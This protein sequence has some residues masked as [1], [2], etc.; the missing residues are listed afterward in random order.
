MN[1]PITRHIRECEIRVDSF[2]EDERTVEV[3]WAAGA[4]VK[5]RSWETGPY[6][7]E[8]SMKPEHIRLDR[9]NSGAMSLLDTHDSWSIENR[10]GTVVA[11]TVRFE[12]GRAF[13]RVKI[14]RK[15]L[16]ERILSD[17][18]DGMP[19]PVSVG[20]KIHAYE[21]KDPAEEG[22]LPTR[23]LIDWEPFEISAVP[24]PA[25]PQAQSRNQE[26]ENEMPPELVEVEDEAHVR[27]PR[28]QVAKKAE[29]R[30]I[31]ARFMNSADDEDR[32][33]MLEATRGMSA[34][35]VRL[36]ILEHRADQED[37]TATHTHYGTDFGGQSSM[38]LRAEALYARMTGNTP[39]EQAR[40]FMEASLLDHAR[41][42]LQERG[43]D[44]RMMGRDEI[45]RRSAMHTTSDFPI[46]LQST[47]LRVLRDA[48]E[49]AR[50]PIRSHLS[51][52]TTLSD[53]R[54]K[55]GVRITDIGL[56][57]KV[58]EHGEVTS[59]TRGE[60][61][62]ESYK[63]DTFARL[64]SMTRQA[65]INDDLSAFSDFNRTAG[66]MAAE[67]ENELLFSILAENAYAGPTMAEDDNAMFHANHG[68][69]GSAVALSVDALSG[70]RKLMR[71]QRAPAN[72]D[73]HRPFLSAKAKYLV[74]GPELETAAEKVLADITATKTDDVNP[75]S[76]KL[77]LLVENRIEDYS[78][79]LFADPAAVPVLEHAYLAGHEGPQIDTREGFEV[80]GMEFRVHLDFGAGGV[81][82]R[83][84]Y[85]NPGAAPV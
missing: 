19:F 80:M 69:T 75:F 10:I 64:F 48:Y 32:A 46:L 59:T 47:G 9:M 28:K 44:T 62:G 66:R 18:A 39:P 34:D 57:G 8:L 14:S 16:G 6:I 43:T 52:A 38:S 81:D 31:I 2:N 37:R 60:V 25:D 45:I 84:A 54:S 63:L 11:G 82:F 68:N 30:E 71:Q 13:C 22:K 49:L 61:K 15:G 73:E 5:R 72:A 7:E 85:R 40:H 23:L 55:Q 29:R 21:E 51:R 42:L 58:N 27:K 70:A 1:K 67:T 12:K 76:G 65:I 83:G 24:V 3:C 77:E 36:A 74:V 53:F 35:E 79:Y 26:M 78:W 17:L 4:K 33:E 56:L 20:Y 41:S 50:S